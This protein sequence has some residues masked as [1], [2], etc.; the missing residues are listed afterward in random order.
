MHYDCMSLPSLMAFAKP[1]VI[2]TW[3]FLRYSDSNPAFQESA[4]RMMLATWLVELYLRKYSELEDVINAGL[5]S[6]DM[7]DRKEELSKIENEFKVFLQT[8]AVNSIFS[9]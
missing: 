2:L 7:T 6:Q 3:V 8:N 9:L 4:K 5:L 1:S